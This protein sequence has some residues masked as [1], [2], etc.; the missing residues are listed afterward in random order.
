MGTIFIMRML[1]VLPLVAVIVTTGAA[2]AKVEDRSGSAEEFDL[3]AFLTQLGLQ[4]ASVGLPI[5][6]PIALDAAGAAA[7]GALDAAGGLL[8]RADLVDIEDRS[9]SAEAFDLVSFLTQLGLQG[10]QV[11]LP[12]LGPIA[13]DAAGAAAGGALDAA[14]GLLGRSD[15]M[16]LIEDR[17]GSK[18][19]EDFDLLALI[20]LLN[21]LVNTFGIGALSGL[22]GNTGTTSG[23]AIRVE[24]NRSGSAEAFDL[25]SFLTQ[26]GLQGAQVG[27]PILG[28]IALDAA[29]AA[30][31]GALDAAGGLL[32]RSD[33]VDIEDRSGSAE[34][35]DL[36]SF[37]TQLGLQGAQVGLPILGPIALDAAGAA[38]GGALDAA[39]GLLGRSDLQGEEVF[40]KHQK[41]PYYGGYYKP[42]FYQNQYPYYNQ[43]S[44]Y[45]YS[46]TN[47]PI[48][49][50]ISSIVNTFGALS[51]ATGTI[52]GSTGTTGTTSGTAI[53]V[54]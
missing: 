53:R 31:G 46:G 44:G 40:L 27:L 26:L 3:V 41:Y 43:Y 8:G 51:G 35:F 54:E 15:L 45:P 21:T 20:N 25:V 52:P 10:A 47:T 7:G 34:A 16:D 13:L 30:A 9:G 36:V 14:G 12:I 17:S 42:P 28:P 2:P 37:L 18:S 19:A 32:G 48:A 1:S 50:L 6:G 5:L 11:G 38:A 39:G 49:N 29:G 33:L 22:T 24:E 23:T 4:G